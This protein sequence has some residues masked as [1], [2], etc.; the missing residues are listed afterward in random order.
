MVTLSTKYKVLTPTI[1]Q[2]K[3][4]FPG[5]VSSAS[6]MVYPAA[7]IALSNGAAWVGSIANNSNNWNTA[8]S[9]GNHASAGYLLAASGIAYDSYRLGGAL[10]STYAPLASPTFTGTVTLPVNQYILAAG[11]YKMFYR[12]ANTHF[13][14]TGATDLQINNNADTATLVTVLNGGNVG[15][16]TITPNSQLTL[17][18]YGNIELQTGNTAGFITHLYTSSDVNDN[19]TLSANFKRTTYISGT[20]PQA[21][22][23]TA[24]IN[25]HTSGAG[26]G[27]SNIDFLTGAVNTVPSIRMRIDSGGNV[28]IG[29]TTGSEKLCVTG[30]QIITSGYLNSEELRGNTTFVSGFAGAGYKLL[31]SGSDY[32]LEVDNL[33]V[34]KNMKAYE[35]DINKINSINGGMLIS[36]ANGTCLTVS[37]TTIYF[38]E[39]GTNKQI[40]FVVDDY[41]RAQVW[42]GR[43]VNSYIGKVTAVNHSTT[44]G[45]AN[46][47]AT[48]I[49]GTPYD[50]MELVQI[51]NSSDATR[52]NLIYLT[53]SDTNNPYIEGH[54]GVTTGVLSDTTRQFRLGNLTGIT[55]PTMGALTGHGLYSQ[56]AFL[57]GR[58][59]LPNAGITN[60]G[61]L[62]SSIRLY[63]GDTYANRATA[64]FRV[65]QDGSLTATGIAELGTNVRHYAGGDFSVG[66]KGSD[67][68]ESS[69]ANYSALYINRVSTGYG[70]SYFR[71]TVI[72]DGKGNNALTVLSYNSTIYTGSGG[73]AWNLDVSGTLTAQGLLTAVGVHIG[74]TSSPGTNNLLVEGNITSNGTIVNLGGSH[75]ISTGASDIT[76][77]VAE[78]DM[79][80]SS[81]TV[82]PKGNKIMILFAAPFYA[83]SNASFT[84]IINV[85][86]SNVRTTRHYCAAGQPFTVMIHHLISVTPA[87]SITIKIRWSDTTA[88]QQRGATDAI[89]EL[90]VID[91]M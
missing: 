33:T 74:G 18:G 12:G 55:D 82:T 17:G 47:V 62:A 53:A 60:E 24:E 72:G 1:L 41:I 28:L 26:N 27:V 40:Q 22:L 71:D 87:S 75:D 80:S 20:I 4:G 64:P 77:A 34:R 57:T 88:I 32:N 86:G 3:R 83:T 11:G 59:V 49:S 50:G 76:C 91:L 31:K 84:L 13:I 78:G 56:N 46:I 61:A 69:G 79:S 6:V 85:G 81:V 54:S 23:G 89:R 44:Y 39:D 8:Y 36:V 90:S 42:T 58:L 19:I 70:T 30:N 63:A 7:G 15:I 45:S 14:F 68:Y 73:G 35:L 52:Q 48:T 43:G 38:D 65:A 2:G 66:I 37:G 5:V 16:G 67:I 9:W 10:A 51:G 25:L 21:L 29:Q